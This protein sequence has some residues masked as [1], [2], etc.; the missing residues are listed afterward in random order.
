MAE[1]SRAEVEGSTPNLFEQTEGLVGNVDGSYRL[2][3]DGNIFQ[4]INQRLRVMKRGSVTRNQIRMVLEAVPSVFPEDWRTRPTRPSR[5]IYDAKGLNEG[6]SK[7]FS[8]L[9][10]L[11]RISRDQL[12]GII[13]TA[14]RFRD[15]SPRLS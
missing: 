13:R 14:V 8:E 2:G 7:F 5:P 1:A 10:N 4:I 11:G 12:E 9:Q 6:Q 15:S 3:K